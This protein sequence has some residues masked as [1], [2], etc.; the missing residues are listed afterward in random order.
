[1][2]DGVAMATRIGKFKPH[3]PNLP[4]THPFKPTPDV[5]FCQSEKGAD[6]YD[7]QKKLPEGGHYYV[8]VF[9]DMTVCVATDDPSTLFPLDYTLYQ[10]EG[11]LD[12]YEA[13]YGQ[14]FDPKTDEFG[15]EDA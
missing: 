3:Q 10:V 2:G 8:G 14:R 7:L 9:D 12:D 15:G 1:M 4:G 13:V 11:S 5:R 6:W